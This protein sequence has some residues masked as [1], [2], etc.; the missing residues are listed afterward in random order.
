MSCVGL[1]QYFLIRF[2]EFTEDH[3]LQLYLSQNKLFWGWSSCALRRPCYNVI[4]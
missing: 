1:I 2:L 4:L 3:K